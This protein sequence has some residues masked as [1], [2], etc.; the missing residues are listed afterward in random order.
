MDALPA[1][2]DF[3]ARYS[4]GEPQAVTTKMVA[5]LETPVS[6]MIKIAGDRP[7]SFLFESVEGGAVRGR[8]SVIGL[9]PDLIF[10]IDDGVASVNRSARSQ[11]DAFEPLKTPPLDALRA[12]IKETR[13]RLPDGVQP[14]SVGIF[15][16]LGYDAVRFIERLP[17]P[18]TN[19]LGL[20]DGMFLRPTITV[21]FDSVTGEVQ[22]TTPV[23]PDPGLSAQAAYDRA[24]ER[25]QDTVGDFGRG[26]G[27]RTAA[28]HGQTPERPVEPVSNMTREAYLE[29]VE[30]AKDYIRAGD[31]FQVVPSQRFSR[32]FTLPPFALYRS[33]R[34]LN[35]SPFLFYLNFGDFSIVGSSP[36]LLVRLRDDTV[37]IRPIAGTR[38]RGAT[39]DEDEA[40]AADLLSDAKEQAEHLMLLDL[41]RNDVG[42]VSETGSVTVTERFTV[43]HYSHVMHLVSNVTGKKRADVD[44]VSALM[45]GFPAGTVSGAPKI[46]AMEIIHELE[47]DRRGL[48]AG[49]VGYFDAA[50]SMDNCIALRTGVVKDGMLHVQAG[51]GVVADSVPQ[52]EFEET[53]N[54]ARAL[55]RAADEATRFAP[56]GAV[57]S[58]DFKQ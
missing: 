42:R 31:I 6:A 32:P 26:L 2:S 14:V 54:K 36:E 23:W 46:R 30:R 52:M 58:P 55:F 24:L 22:I 27:A 29:S 21:V 1:Y 34:R 10:R 17:E 7:L 12:L 47:P 9:K 8:Y 41:G 16:F 35:P 44:A 33:L 19:T 25:L 39:R 5:D 15:G 43:E 38:P 13:V 45:A 4:A 57:A 40:L 28:H 3:A 51:G 20:P 11:P 50:G 18:K 37:T 49:M 53:V 56:V 48:Y